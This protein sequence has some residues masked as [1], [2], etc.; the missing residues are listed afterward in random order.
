MDQEKEILKE[1]KEQAGSEIKDDNEYFM[2]L[3]KMKSENEKDL[4]TLGAAADDIDPGFDIPAK[5]I[6]EKMHDA[7]LSKDTAIDMILEL[8]DN[9]YIE[10]EVRLFGGK[11][12]A[13]FK[14]AKLL[15]SKAFVDVF[16]AMDINTQAKG[17]YY[18]N[19]YALASVLIEF[20][21]EKLNQEDV[22]DRAKWIENNLPVPIYKNLISK[23]NDFHAKIELLG[24]DEVANFF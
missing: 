17:E 8:S 9:G 19:L 5:T 11:F 23:A 12:T 16:D 7:G 4:D 18:L 1:L 3:D 6:E 20:Q 24:S 22:R 13:K 21:D 10:E 15:D 14:T 2:D